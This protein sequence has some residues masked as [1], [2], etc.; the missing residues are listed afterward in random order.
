MIALLRSRACVITF[1]ILALAVANV[2]WRGFEADRLIAEAGLQAAI[3]PQA[4]F[5]EFS[6]LPE[7]FHMSR[8]QARGTMV[9][10]DASGVRLRGVSPDSMRAIAAQ[11]WVARLRRLED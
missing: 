11:P 2:T 7:Q 4:I 6:V 8:L 1:L 10:A 5:V 3:G 9:G